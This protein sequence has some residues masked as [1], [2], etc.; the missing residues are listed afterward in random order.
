MK[1]RLLIALV[2]GS[3]T[4]WAQDPLPDFI[5]AKKLID[6]VEIFVG[7]SVHFPDDN[8][9]YGRIE[10]G[11]HGLM[12]GRFRT[13]A[14]Y[15]AGV[16]GTH[17]MGQAFQVNGRLAWD[18]K[19]YLMEDIALGANNSIHKYKAD[20]QNDYISGVLALD[21]FFRKK[22]KLYVSS[23][24]F[25][26]HLLKSLTRET[27]HL[28]GQITQVSFIRDNPEIRKSD[29]GLLFAIGYFLQLSDNDRLGLRLQG[30]YGLV[31]VVKVNGL[32]I[33][34]NSLNLQITFRRDRATN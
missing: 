15:M 14:G 26:S 27:S 31:D 2:V 23:G 28:N 21:F 7:P 12:R 13:K 24:I 4:C 1:Q 11:S 5:E 8:G 10:R 25:Y 18:R 19:G 6:Q 30:N 33:N 29:V 32:V 3:V 9:W 16:S 17:S 20:T 34:V 22:S